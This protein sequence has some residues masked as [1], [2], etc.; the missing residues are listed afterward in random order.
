MI[1]S[2]NDISTGKRH[3][4]RS[5]ERE[6]A[7]AVRGVS[8]VHCKRPASNRVRFRSAG[9]SRVKLWR[10]FLVAAAEHPFRRRI[11]RANDTAVVDVIIPSRML[12]ITDEC[13]SGALEFRKLPAHENKRSCWNHQKATARGREGERE[14]AK[15]FAE[16]PNFAQFIKFRFVFPKFAAFGGYRSFSVFARSISASIRYLCPRVWH[17][18]LEPPIC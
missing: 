14:C 8:S 7:A 4:S 18:L 16:W 15:S 1:I 3:A 6:D 12:S 10:S 17:R 5:T 9:T 11:H 2:L 13:V